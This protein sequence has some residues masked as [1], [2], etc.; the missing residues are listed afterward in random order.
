MTY[1]VSSRMLNPTIPYH[2]VLVV[3]AAVFSL[4]LY[5]NMLRFV[6]A[7]TVRLSVVYFWNYVTFKGQHVGKNIFARCTVLMLV[8]V[9]LYYFS[10]KGL[11]SLNFLLIC[12]HQGIRY[13]RLW[14]VCRFNVEVIKFSNNSVTT[15]TEI[16]QICLCC[17]SSCY[18]TTIVSKFII[19]KICKNLAYNTHSFDLIMC[20]WI[21]SV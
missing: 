15:A 2:S 14:V 16:Q 6:Y 12:T 8:I 4:L 13:N 3:S 11:H 19:V 10:W 5:D 21:K 9:V 7:M 18:A 1:N 20:F 17:S